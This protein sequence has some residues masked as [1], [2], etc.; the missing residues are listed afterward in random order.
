[1]LKFNHDQAANSPMND[2]TAK[3]Q[4]SFPKSKRFVEPVSN[5]GKFYDIP[6]GFSKRSTSF[7]YGKKS[8]F[9]GGKEK[10]PDPGTYH[11]NTDIANGTTKVSFGISR[12]QCKSYVEGHF[13]ADPSIPG[14]G[15]YSFTPKFAKEGTKYSILGKW[16]QKKIIENNPGP[17]AYNGSWNKTS[18]QY[19]VSNV[20]N[21]ESHLFPPKSS[22]RFPK[23]NNDKSPG[24]WSYQ[25]DKGIIGN[26]KVLSTC[27]SSGSVTFA[28]TA[29]DYNYGIKNTP[30]PGSYRLPSDFGYYDVGK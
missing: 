7:G 22:S 16:P 28:M 6:S 18:G 23:I 29:R 25:T 9:T 1:M 21:L 19:V 24:P 13:K 14:P 5:S 2:S 17:G 15:T 8:D 30:G 10:T 4:Y 26:S 3:A 11:I 12:E 20:K 27:K